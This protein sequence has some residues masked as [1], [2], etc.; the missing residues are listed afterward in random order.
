VVARRADLGWRWIRISLAAAGLI[1]GIV[2]ASPGAAHAAGSDAL[3]LSEAG[4]P[5]LEELRQTS[6]ID[7]SE[8]RNTERGKRARYGLLIVDGDRLGADAFD[9]RPL[10][11]R[12]VNSGRWIMTLDAARSDLQAIADFTGF[13]LSEADEI[14]AEMLLFR[15]GM[16]QG[17]PMI[18]V[19]R[20]GQN[21][22]PGAGD[23]NDAERDRVSRIAVD[24]AAALAMAR[25][26]LDPADG[27]ARIQGLAAA[28]DLT[29]NTDCPQVADPHAPDMIHVAWCLTDASQKAPGDGQW[30]TA[31]KPWWI[32]RYEAGK[33]TA[34]WAI[35][36]RFDVYLNYNSDKKPSS[37]TI[38][39]NVD[40]TFDPAGG[41]A[42]FHMNDPFT[43]GWYNAGRTPIQAE[44]AWWTGQVNP[45][46]GSQTGGVTAIASHP[47]NSN[48]ASQYST[49]D[50][51]GVALNIA[52]PDSAGLN[53][54]YQTTTGQTWE[55]KDWDVTNSQSLSGARWAFS[56]GATDDHT[57]CRITSQTPVANPPDGCFTSYDKGLS[58]PR[59]PNPLSRGRFP[60]HAN[61]RFLTQ[62]L[63][64]DDA[65]PIK[66]R[67]ENEVTLYSTY[68]SK[69][70][71]FSAPLCGGSTYHRYIPQYAFGPTAKVVSVYP[72]WVIPSNISSL[73]F[74]RQQ[75]PGLVG[76]DTAKG[77]EQ[78]TGTIELGKARPVP[79]EVKVFSN[80]E[81]AVLE[82]TVLPGVPGGSSAEVDIPRGQK[83]GTFTIRTNRNHLPAEGIT[84]GI[85]A[86]YGGSVRS[87]DLLI[88]RP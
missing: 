74:Q 39:H 11:E 35:N 61:T 3:V 49:S 34:T 71:F 68:C 77:G 47:E 75:G 66:F 31:N 82:H 20:G 8:V 21:G 70:D 42:F 12:F 36:H 62:S 73:R 58:I 23:L 26:G 6:D 18:E 52:K 7:T 59:L 44:R 48:S 85:T 14:A 33:Q 54:S 46:I 1:V 28:E 4:N 60:Y 45:A 43:T 16:E 15:V 17:T 80:S 24:R 86:V 76:T 79:V 63:V 41:G 19:V 22:A 51:F 78:I 72:S 50:T 10:I 88:E 84:A 13:G 32:D 9:D 64:S 53:L 67:I 83:T 65:S 5:I 38:L 55:L 25:T 57:A 69:G 56:A 40:G 27:N 81:N 29:K 87:E 30:T 2:A 37:Q